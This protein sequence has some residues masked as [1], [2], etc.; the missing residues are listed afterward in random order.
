MAIGLTAQASGAALN[1]RLGQV[2]LNVR[3]SLQ[4]AQNF[5][6]EIAFLGVPG[7]GALPNEPFGTAANPANPNSNS[8]AQEFFNEANYLAS[9]AKF[10]FGTLPAPAVFN[11]DSGTEQARGGN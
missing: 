1:A 3:N 9:V 11:Y 7:L 2:A 6:Q 4:D 8:D 10:Y 5:F